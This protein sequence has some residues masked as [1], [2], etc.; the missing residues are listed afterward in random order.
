M[1]VAGELLLDGDMDSSSS[2]DTRGDIQTGKQVVVT[3]QTQLTLKAHTSGVLING[4]T[5]LR[6]RSGI[7][8][9]DHVQGVDGNLAI[10]ADYGS[11]MNGVLTVAQGKH[12]EHLG[13]GCIANDC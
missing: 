1:G 4:D 10:N 8:L 13:I 11:T 5:T 7:M 9:W 6:A 3:A 2:N 12:I